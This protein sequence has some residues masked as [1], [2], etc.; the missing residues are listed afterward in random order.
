MDAQPAIDGEQAGVEGY[1][2]SRAGSQ[3]I[4][5]IQAL[6][7]RAVLPWLDMTGQEHAPG[8]ERRRTETAE[9][10]SATTIP[11][12]V[13]GEYMLPDPGRRR[14]DPLGLLQRLSAFH[15]VARDFLPQVR[16][17]SGRLEFILTEQEQLAAVFK[18]QEIRQTTRGYA[19][20]PG[21][22]QEHP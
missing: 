16:L 10:A 12:H 4:T 11:Q 7:R 3:A 1:V 22:I 6:G 19:F 20:G 14:E 8:T 9:Y 13:K 2:V 18:L 15:S 21:R 17:Q 5:E